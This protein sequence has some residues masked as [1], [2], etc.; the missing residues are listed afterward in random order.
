MFYF[1]L[2]SAG[3]LA[4]IIGALIGIGGGVIIVPFLVLFLGISMQK[5]IAIS[6]ATIVLV[7]FITSIYNI[8]NHLVNIKL[9]LILEISTALCAIIAS[10]IAIGINSNILKGIFGIFLFFVSFLILKPIHF[11]TKKID[12]KMSYSYFDP[13]FKKVIYYKVRHLKIAILA[14]SL[15]GIASGTL[16]IGGGV[17]KVP[18]LNEICQIPM[19]VSTATSNLMVGITAFSAGFVY[20][21]YGY[22]D[23]KFLQWVILGTIIGSVIGIYIKRH[24][25]N[26]S[27]KEIFSVIMLIVGIIMIIKS[28]SL[29]S[30][31]GQAKLLKI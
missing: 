1:C 15:A 29:F 19:R 3:I 25:D 26:Y 5:A 28:L 31:F 18:I 9:A 14:S 23:M 6:L 20:F 4:S 16:G 30:I 12:G 13:D 27:I 24:L 7:S 10:K 2:F 8:K 17:L 22:L 21:N 11:R